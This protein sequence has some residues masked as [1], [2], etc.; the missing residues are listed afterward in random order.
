MNEIPVLYA[1]NEGHTR[2]IAELAPTTMANAATEAPYRM[3]GDDTRSTPRY[4][5]SIGAPESTG[6]RAR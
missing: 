3:N 1:T 6:A 5:A 2:R 4:C